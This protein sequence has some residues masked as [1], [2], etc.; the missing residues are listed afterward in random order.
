M[1]S[2]ITDRTFWSNDGWFINLRHGDENLVLFSGKRRVNLRSGEFGV[3][4]GP[5]TSLVQMESWFASFLTKHGKPRDIVSLN[6][7]ANAGVNATSL[8]LELLAIEDTWL[9]EK[10]PVRFQFA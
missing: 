10:K 5:F 2:N 7:G 6:S 3:I 9:Q 4:A 8:T 1:K